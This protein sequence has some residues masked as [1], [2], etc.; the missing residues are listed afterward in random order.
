MCSLKGQPGATFLAVLD[1]VQISFYTTDVRNS[2]K[3]MWKRNMKAQTK[4]GRECPLD[5]SAHLTQLYSEEEDTET[6]W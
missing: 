3:A 2:V 6:K 1:T 4:Q 5:V